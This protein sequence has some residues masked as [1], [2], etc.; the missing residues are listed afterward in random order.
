MATGLQEKAA[1]FGRLHRHGEPIA[2]IRAWDAADLL[3]PLFNNPI[4]G[5]LP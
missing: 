5:K 4:E 3:D 2:P 1:T